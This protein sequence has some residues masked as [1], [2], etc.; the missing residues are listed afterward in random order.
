MINF[1]RRIRQKLADDNKPLKYAR[2]A[3]GEIVLVVVG[4]LI[5]LQIN[6]WNE[7]RKERKNETQILISLSED[8]KSNLLA[9]EHSINTIPIVI[10]NYS[11]VLE[12]AGK[13]QNG[14]T[15]EMKD[16]IIN[17]GFVS[18][19]IVDGA[20]ISILGSD[21]LE[22]I[23]NDSLKRLLTAY[24]AYIKDFER[25]QSFLEEYVRD[26][27]RPMVRSYL[28]LSDLLLNEPRFD[29]LKENIIKSD[30]E[31]LLKNRD[32][33]NVVIGIRSINQ[34]L[35]NECKAFHALTKEINQSIEREILN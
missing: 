25:S 17:T 22:I 4:I 27:Q 16:T 8:F 34:N 19:N 12:Y 11:L 2:Y 5:A 10:E 14:L 26:I 24:P 31:G 29:E 32:Y 35:L 18:A 33:L 23:R 3:I 30:Y 15:K 13:L 1:F 21:R 9:L 7:D 20:L 6:I 28:S